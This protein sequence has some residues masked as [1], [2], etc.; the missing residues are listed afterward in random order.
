MSFSYVTSLVWRFCPQIQTYCYVSRGFI[1]Q[2]W[3]LGETTLTR[4]YSPIFISKVV[5]S[6]NNDQQSERKTERT[7]CL[8]RETEGGNTL[9]PSPVSLD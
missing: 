8:V 2:T 4:V 1:E 5:A 3:L 6:K 7:K 9:A